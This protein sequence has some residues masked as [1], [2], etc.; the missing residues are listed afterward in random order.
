MTPTCSQNQSKTDEQTLPNKDLT[1]CKKYQIVS[2]ADTLRTSQIELSLKRNISFHKIQLR[3]PTHGPSPRKQRQF[4]TSIKMDTNI[5]AKPDT[6]NSSEQLS[7]LGPKWTPRASHV[8][9]R[10]CQMIMVP[11]ARRIAP[12][13]RLVFAKTFPLSR[14]RN[15]AGTANDTA[16]TAPPRINNHGI[17]AVHAR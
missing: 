5:N 1:N 7:K 15:H 3:F 14:L 10:I 12:G 17:V 2:S 11:I 6:E 8:I 16:S 4:P 9:S 13:F